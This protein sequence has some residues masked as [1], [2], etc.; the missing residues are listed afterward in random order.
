[1][2]LPTEA[3]EPLENLAKLDPGSRAV[4]LLQGRLVPGAQRDLHQR[5]TG[6]LRTDLRIPQQRPVG[7]QRYRCRRRP[8]G[9]GNDLAEVG[10]QRRLAAAGHGDGVGAVPRREPLAE[11]LDHHR[12]RDV[13]P[14]L[15]RQISRPAQ[16]TEDAI[17]IAGLERNQVD[18]QRTAQAPRRH[19][20]K[21]MTDGRC[22]HT[23][24]RSLR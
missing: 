7:Q 2:E 15:H 24:D 8:T 22:I 23:P 12:R 21:Q 18:A 6:G 14:A 10:V 4:D 1:M 9:P 5:R 3:L 17:E 13:R 11:F 20:T 16:L 19:R